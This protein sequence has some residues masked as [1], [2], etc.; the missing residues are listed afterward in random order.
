MFGGRHAKQIIRIDR[1]AEKIFIPAY[2]F[3]C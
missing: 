2:S 1:R 3:T